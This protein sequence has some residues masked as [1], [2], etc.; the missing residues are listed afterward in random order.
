VS[1]G[2]GPLISGA[3]P[4]TCGGRDAKGDRG[5]CNQ[6]CN[7]AGRDGGGQQSD[8]EAPNALYPPLTRGAGDSR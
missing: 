4:L 7:R 8:S 2:A 1:H 5:R 3:A 6:I